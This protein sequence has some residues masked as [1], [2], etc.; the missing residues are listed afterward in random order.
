MQ[1]VVESKFVELI[2]P[3]KDDMQAQCLPVSKSNYPSW[4]CRKVPKLSSFK[5]YDKVPTW[6]RKPQ[7][8]TYHLRAEDITRAGLVS[9]L[10]KEEKTLSK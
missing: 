2:Q 10:S 7:S 1:S 8:F 9:A 5:N 4:M 3:I 6:C